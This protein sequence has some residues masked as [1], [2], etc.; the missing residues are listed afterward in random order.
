[1]TILSDE[2]L[3]SLEIDGTSTQSCPGEFDSLPPA[4][5]VVHSVVVG[6]YLAA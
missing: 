1:M 2:E 6:K 3:Q 5:R 4:G